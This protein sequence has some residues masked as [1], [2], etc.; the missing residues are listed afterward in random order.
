M[1]QKYASWNKAIAECDV[2]GQQYKRKEL[3]ELIVKTKKT[4]IQACPAC[5]T[6]DQPQLLVGMYPVDDPQAIENPRPDTS[7][8]QSGP[9]GLQLQTVSPPDPYAKTAFGYP[10]EGSRVIQWGWN[11]V[12]LDNT[13]GLFGLE[14]ML[15]APGE[16]GDVTVTIS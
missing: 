16:T 1:P 10:S 7:Y 14:D 13:L 3:K 2:C 15:E 8:W 6:P 9:T 4:N 11:P 12:G 5:W